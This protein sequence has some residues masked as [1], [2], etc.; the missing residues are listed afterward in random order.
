MLKK[1]TALKNKKG[2]AAIELIPTLFIFMLIINFGLGFFGAVHAGILHNI[3][4]R[5]YT[6]ETMRH[7]ANLVYHRTYEPQKNFNLRGYR[8]GGIIYD[9]ATTGDTGWKAAARPIAFSSSWGGTDTTNGIDLSIR[10]P[11]NEANAKTVHNN[12]VNNLNEAA[13][14]DK[15]SVSQIWIKELYGICIDATCGDK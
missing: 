5:N 7:R 9:N 8:F 13:R 6:F 4:A 12:D 14:N 3:A 10:G 2:M 1:M 11:A 15:V